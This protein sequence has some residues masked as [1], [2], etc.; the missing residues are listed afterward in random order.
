ML[1]V[2]SSP[3]LAILVLQLIEL[4]GGGGGGRFFF[5]KNFLKKKKNF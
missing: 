4:R 2:F 1:L 3:D 5:F